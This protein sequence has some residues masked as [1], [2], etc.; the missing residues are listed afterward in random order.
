MRNCP[1]CSE[2]SI[3]LWQLAMMAAFSIEAC[4][5][6]C[7]SKVTRR[8]MNIIIIIGLPAVTFFTGVGVVSFIAVFLVTL[9]I[10]LVLS[11][12]NLEVVGKAYRVPTKKEK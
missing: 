5:S 3:T 7:K 6:N 9:V 1:N 10:S 11:L 2:S 8:S 12:K 4:C